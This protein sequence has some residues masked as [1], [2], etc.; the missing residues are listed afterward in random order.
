MTRE[1]NLTQQ[2]QQQHSFF[3]VTM[4]IVGNKN[5]M[6]HNNI[7]PREYKKSIRQSISYEYIFWSIYI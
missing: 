2:Q 4:D 5:R 1:I 6:R 7:T 3:L